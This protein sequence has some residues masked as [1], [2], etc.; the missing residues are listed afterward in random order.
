MMVLKL[1]T[2][3]MLGNFAYLFLLSV[4]FFFQKKAF[5]S[6]KTF[7]NTIIVSITLDPDQAL[8]FSASKL[9]DNKSCN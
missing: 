7:R 9:V 4:H 8:L 6:K 3:C 2:L 1:F 5:L